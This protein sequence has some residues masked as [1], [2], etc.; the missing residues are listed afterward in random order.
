[1]SAEDASPRVQ[2]MSSSSVVTV[3][4]C[5]GSLPAVENA[6]EG[7]ADRIEVCSSLVEGGVTPS[8]GMIAATC[9]MAAEIGERDVEVVALIRPREGDFF[10]S[11]WSGGGSEW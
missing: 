5:A 8:A 6:L 9:A 3:E 4:I 1:M 11:G 7:G 10:Y 2:E